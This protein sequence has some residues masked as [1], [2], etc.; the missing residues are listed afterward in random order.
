[1]KSPKTQ[2]NVKTTQGQTLILKSELLISAV[3]K[4]NDRVSHVKI[5]LPNYYHKAIYCMA[6]QTT[7]PTEAGKLFSE[8][9]ECWDFISGTDQAQLLE[10]RQNGLIAHEAL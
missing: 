6:Y 8:D 5:T 3:K 2:K 9:S 10:L 4:F 7:S 1:M